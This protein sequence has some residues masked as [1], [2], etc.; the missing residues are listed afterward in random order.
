MN[1]PLAANS[2]AICIIFS[3]LKRMAKAAADFARS[4]YVAGKVAGTCFQQE[5]ECGKWTPIIAIWKATTRSSFHSKMQK[6]ILVQMAFATSMS[7]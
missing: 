2:A 5:W 6:A 4:Q 1:T 7:Q 3:R